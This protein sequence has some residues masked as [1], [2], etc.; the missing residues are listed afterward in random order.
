MADKEKKSEFVVQDRRRFSSEG[1]VTETAERQEETPAATPPVTAPPPPA[2]GAQPE[3]PPP[4]SAAEQSAQHGDY[5]QASQQLDA[6]LETAGVKRPPN[7]E[8]TFEALVSSLYFQAMMQLG[9]VREESTPPRPDIIGARHTIDMIAV[10]GEKTKG[11][12]T[13]RESHLLQNVLF[14]LRMAFLEI[15]NAI[16]NAP[17]PGKPAK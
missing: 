12:L 7:L 17:P 8:P 13:E 5:Q 6:M 15:T 11:N 2:A 9:M 4:P 14:E 1:E 10:L 3:V 16:A